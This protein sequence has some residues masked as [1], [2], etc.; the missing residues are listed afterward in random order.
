MN[1]SLRGSSPSNLIGKEIAMAVKV[2][3]ANEGQILE[4][5][6][7]GKLTDE[8]YAHFV[9]EIEELIRRYGKVRILFGMEDFHGWEASALWQDVKFDFKHHADIE[10]LAVVG[11]K[12]WQEWMA[13][14]CKPFTSAT[15]RYFDHGALDEARQWVSGK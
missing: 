6:A 13:S 12:K 9:P 3:K 1:D 11:E 10:R 15:I 4:V 14:F 7:T 5:H 2:E 8:D